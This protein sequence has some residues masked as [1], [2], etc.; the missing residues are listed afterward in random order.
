[1]VEKINRNGPAARINDA[2]SKVN[3]ALWDILSNEN[4]DAY[5]YCLLVTKNDHTDKSEYVIRTDKNRI[6]IVNFLMD[7]LD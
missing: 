4:K 3:K 2:K 5:Y 1:M 7:R 6:H